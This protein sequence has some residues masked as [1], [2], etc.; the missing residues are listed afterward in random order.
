MPQKLTERIGS[1]DNCVGFIDG[2]AIGIARPDDG[3]LQRVVYNGTKR[4]HALKFQAVT[5]ATVIVLHVHGPVEGRRHDW[6]LYYRYGLEEQLEQVLT[7]NGQKFC[8]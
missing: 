2:T 6:T 1:L 7:V 8:L 4:K 5:T 3:G